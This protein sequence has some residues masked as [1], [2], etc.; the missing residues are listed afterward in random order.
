MTL[1][2]SIFV[3]TIYAKFDDNW[4]FEVLFKSR[5]FKVQVCENSKS[6]RV[7][8]S[9]YFYLQSCTMI[10]FCMN[11]CNSMDII[12]LK[13]MLLDVLVHN[14]CVH[15]TGWSTLPQCST[16]LYPLHDILIPYFLSHTLSS[17]LCQEFR[18]CQLCSAYRFN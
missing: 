4:N 17:R 11:A 1:L 8:V 3:S 14:Y 13:F 15:C 9:T 5:K 7:L 12:P 18:K 10:L 2:L 16:Q 6:N